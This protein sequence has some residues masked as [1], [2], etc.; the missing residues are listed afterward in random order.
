MTIVDP[1]AV[2]AKAMA[3]R[4]VAKE[5]LESLKATGREARD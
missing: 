3:R 4:V 5:G 1:K 2:E